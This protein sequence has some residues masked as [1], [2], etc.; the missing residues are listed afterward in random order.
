MNQDATDYTV[1]NYDDPLVRSWAAH[2]RGQLC[3]FSRAKELERGVFLRGG[4][5]VIRWGGKELTVCHKDE[6]HIFGGHNEENVLAALACAYFAGVTPD[7]MRQVLRSFQPLEHRL[8]YVET[9]AGVPYYNDSKA[10]NTDSAVKALQAFPQGHVVLLAGVYDKGT[11]LAELMQLV[12]ER[13]DAL[14]LFGAARARFAAAAEEA[15]VTNITQVET[16]AQALA[17]ARQLTV[18]PQVVL[19]S[20]ACSSY[21]QFPNFVVRGRTFKE[22]VRKLATDTPGREESL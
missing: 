7:D 1:L 20:P 11:P 15:G 21:D 3:Y 17:V 6:L 14:V 10:T 5:F 4:Q 18:P 22:L 12:R 13:A 8:E 9:I 16:L 19:F 2:T